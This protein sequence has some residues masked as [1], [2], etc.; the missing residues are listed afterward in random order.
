MASAGRLTTHVLDTAAGRPAA[1]VVVTLLRQR[2]GGASI[3]TS[4]RTNADGRTDEPL[5]ASGAL[6]SGCY[7]LV[8]EVSRYFEGQ[9]M[10]LPEPPFLDRVCI[11]FGVADAEA[12]YHVPLLVSPWSYATYR[13]S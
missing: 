8:F 6:L 13:G 10:D 9:G 4:M 2:R 11:R 3:V 1:G 7:E 5:L 12:D